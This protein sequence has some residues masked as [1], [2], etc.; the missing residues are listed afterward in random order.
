MRRRI[1]YVTEA[2][3]MRVEQLLIFCELFKEEEKRGI[4]RLQ[5]EISQGYVV[6]ADQIPADVVTIHAQVLLKAL[7]TGKQFWMTLVFPEE[8]DAQKNRISV[9]APISI[10]LL[11]A[12][13][14][15][16]VNWQ[17]HAGL[18]DL[19]IVKVIHYPEKV[20][21]SGAMRKKRLESPIENLQ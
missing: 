17:A 21:K 20:A 18:H 5:F 10:L 13:A 19:K 9:L 14:G 2:D 6:S 4:R 1:I 16:I 15:D 12:R 11:G 7:D 3:R 8:A